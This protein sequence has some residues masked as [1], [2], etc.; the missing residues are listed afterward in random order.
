MFVNTGTLSIVWYI[1]PGIQFFIWGS[2]FLLLFP[3][4]WAAVIV[5]NREIVPFCVQVASPTLLAAL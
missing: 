1:Y 2:M 5:N 4:G 3:E